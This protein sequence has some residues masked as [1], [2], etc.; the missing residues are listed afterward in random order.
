MRVEAQILQRLSGTGNE[1]SERAERLRERAVNKRDALFH[2]ELLSRSTAMLAT[3]QH[4]VCLI[5]ENAGVM[6]FCYSQQVSQIS[7]IAVHGVNA[8]NDHKL[9][10][11][12]L[13]AQSGVK[14]RGII[15]LEFLC[16]TSGQHSTVAKTQMRAV[17]Q[18]RDVTF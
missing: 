8:L 11:A 15:V 4:R 6:R 1:A 16:P 12:F 17:V 18:D 7:E 3:C 10:S 5:N 14:R 9:T 13:T 2:G